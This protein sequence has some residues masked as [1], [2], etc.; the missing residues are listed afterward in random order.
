MLPVRYQVPHE[1]P[2]VIAAGTMSGCNRNCTPDLLPRLTKTLP[3][4]LNGKPAGGR[5]M[6]LSGSGSGRMAHRSLIR[7]PANDTTTSNSLTACWSCSCARPAVHDPTGQAHRGPLQ[8]AKT[9]KIPRCRQ[10][11]V[12]DALYRS[13]TRVRCGPLCLGPYM[14]PRGHIAHNA[15]GKGKSLCP[16][17]RTTV[18][19]VKKRSPL[20]PSV[21]GGGS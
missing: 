10:T 3:T 8:S 5:S 17:D 1:R 20:S 18:S 9:R 12:R 4:H 2:F 19:P 21:N 15:I 13:T 11:S 16:V 6:E 7:E 14:L